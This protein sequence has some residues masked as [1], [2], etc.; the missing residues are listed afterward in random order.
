MVSSPRSSSVSNSAPPVKRRRPL[1]RGRWCWIAAV[2]LVCGPSASA[3]SRSS[4]AAA[5]VR[6][7]AQAQRGQP[8]LA[9]PPTP[10]PPTSS[11]TPVVSAAAENAAA[12]ALHSSPRVVAPPANPGTAPR[13]G[14]AAPDSGAGVPQDYGCAAALSYLRANA[15]PGFTFHCPGNAYGHQAMTCVNHAPQCPNSM[16]IAISVP[17]RAAYMNEANNSWILSG[18]RSG[19]IDPYGYCH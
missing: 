18:L 15:A 19:R 6:M 5:D 11:P 13:A 9:P 2:L 12:V 16:I 1:R 14:A 8:S 17:C 10:V 4:P 7:V 3:I